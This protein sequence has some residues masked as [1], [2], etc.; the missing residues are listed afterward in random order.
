VP[1]IMSST[2]FQFVLCLR[3]SLQDYAR[4]GDEDT[5]QPDDAVFL[6]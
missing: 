2:A 5:R 3:S 4:G 6:H 1:R